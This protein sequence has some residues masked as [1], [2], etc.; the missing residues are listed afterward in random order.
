VPSGGSASPDSGLVLIH[1]RFET[2]GGRQRENVKPWVRSVRPRPAPLRSA[3]SPAPAPLL[4]FKE[5][6]FACVS[7][8][9][10]RLPELLTS[11]A[12]TPYFLTG[13]W[14]WIR[15]KQRQKQTNK[16]K[17]QTNITRPPKNPQHKPAVSR[18]QGEQGSV[19]ELQPLQGN[20]KGLAMFRLPFPRVGTGEGQKWEKCCFGV[21]TCGFGWCL[22]SRGR[23]K[24]ACY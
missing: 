21:K 9:D 3:S 11:L 20:A 13:C 23:E 5:Q 4:L 16:Q 18:G 19:P 6:E 8:F 15:L 10:E 12:F 2:V 22:L 14:L 17:P 24:W 7:K 1:P